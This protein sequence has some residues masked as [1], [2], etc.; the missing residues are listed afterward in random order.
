MAER[1]NLTERTLAN[2]TKCTTPIHR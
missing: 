2:P 1:R